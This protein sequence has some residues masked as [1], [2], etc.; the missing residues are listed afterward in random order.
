[1]LVVMALFFLVSMVAAY[2]S[3]NLVFEQRTSANQYRATIAFEAAEA[4]VAWALAQ[5]NSGRV[6]AAC[7]PSTDT[8]WSD[9]RT[10]YLQIDADSGIVAATPS[11]VVGL[12]LGPSCVRTESGWSC[13][14]PATGTTAL[15]AEEGQDLRPA[16]RVEFRSQAGNVPGVLEITSTG[17]TA[18]SNACLVNAAGTAADAAARV[19]V[20]AAL[21][22]G[23]ATI[24]AAA[25]TLRGALNPASTVVAVNEDSASNGITVH[26]G[27][28]VAASVQAISVAGTPSGESL[29]GN[30]G[31]LAGLDVDRFFARF[32][33][34]S[35]TDYAQQPAVVNLNC[36]G[37]C[38][39][40]LA[41][42]VAANPGRPIL[43]QDALELESAVTLG[44]PDA[45]VVL[46]SQGPV[47]LGG[48]T[49]TG[50]VYSRAANWQ[51]AGSGQV[52]GALLAEGDLT[53][54]TTLT[55]RYD[56]AVLD[57]IRHTQGSVI[58]LPGGW[59]DF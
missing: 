47:Q 3:R 45:P 40:A 30:D 12:R 14:C 18:A 59:R 39:T 48:S 8:S 44:S 10:R 27:G 1:L 56:A 25:I 17:C 37:G 42:A 21:T 6:N 13:Q 54:A 29:R 22:P 19:R 52:S 2:S 46:V 55:I 34:M 20:V 49:I 41:A 43:V 58:R 16:F 11:G 31:S 24:P 32:F 28:A 23:L 4:G 15:A 57:R 35:P 50:V 9:F 36:G 5:L 33:G 26:A 7:E 38:S 53:G 51:D